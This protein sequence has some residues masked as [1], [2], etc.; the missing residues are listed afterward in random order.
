[1]GSTRD[2]QRQVFLYGRPGCHLCEDAAELL[3]RLA[4]RIP[5]AIV[6]VNILDDVDLYERCKNSIP[7]VTLDGGPTLAAPIRAAEL[8]RLLIEA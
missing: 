5:I 2:V 7:V 6:E 4:R 8:E 1:M 3:E